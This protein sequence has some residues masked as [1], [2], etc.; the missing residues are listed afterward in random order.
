M[1]KR[2]K[3][4]ITVGSG[5]PY[6]ME[7]TG[8]AMPTIEELFAEENLLGYCKGGAALTYTGELYEEKDDLGLVS[9]QIITAEEVILKLGLLTWNGESLAIMTD[10]CKV[11]EAEGKRTI[12]L[13]GAGN[14]Q[15]KQWVIGF[16]HED[17]VDGNLW[18]MMR[19][20][21]NSGFTLTLAADAGT[22]LEPEFK[23]LAQ[24]ADGTLVTIIEEMD[25]A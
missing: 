1:P 13:G 12:K 14:S 5:K 21:N 24:D 20:Q 22:V 17:K 7:Y 23:G 3:K 18:I 11:T 16:L 9:K 25:A 2:D 8:D 6:A 10:R 19:G 15:G 4:T